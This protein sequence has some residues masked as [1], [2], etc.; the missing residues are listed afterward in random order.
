[1]YVTKIEVLIAHEGGSVDTNKIGDVICAAIA[2]DLRDTIFEVRDGG[3]RAVTLAS[4]IYSLE[5]REP[6]M[7]ATADDDL[8]PEP[9]G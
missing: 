9:H 6:L 4:I 3:T 5:E 7:P 8:E 1:M 2:E